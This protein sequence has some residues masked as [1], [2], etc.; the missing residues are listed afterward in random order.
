MK[1]KYFA[2]LLL[3]LIISSCNVIAQ[4]L[5]DI[6]YTPTEKINSL[7]MDTTISASKNFFADILFDPSGFITFGPGVYLEPAITE[8]IGV[9]AG[10][11]FPN[12]ALLTNLFYGS[13]EMSYS[14]HISLRFYTNPKQ[15]IQGFFLG[16]AIEFGRTNRSSWYDFMNRVFGGEI[17]YKWKYKNGFSLEICDDIGLIQSK[18]VKNSLPDFN[19]INEDYSWFNDRFVFYLLS[20]K[21]GI[22]F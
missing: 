20:V 11:R 21:I 16:P 5:D 2:S 8:N 14:A 4:E 10:V 17:G 19:D 6:Y 13:L 3:I 18:K 1:N 12:L 9:L 7:K 15:K 22:S